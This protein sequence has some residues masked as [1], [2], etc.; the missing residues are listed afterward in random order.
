MLKQLSIQNIALI[1]QQSIAFFDGFS[2]LTGETGAGK[3][4]I[5][6]ALNFVL[7]ERASRELIKSGEEK[8]S[9]EATFALLR[10]DPVQEVLLEQGIDCEEG[11]LVLYREFSAS[12]K[13]VCRANGTLINAGALKLIGDALVDIHGQHAHQS[14]LDEKK[15]LMLLDRFAGK[16]AL[17]IKSR[18]L[19]AYHKAT[20]AR[21]LLSAAQ[22]NEQERI[23]RIDLLSYQ[24]K[25]INAA[26]LTD[27]E[28]EQ[29]E[30]QRGLLQ[31]AQAVMEGLE[32]ASVA[33]SGDEAENG[34]ALA[35]FSTAL[36]NLDGIAHLSADYQQLSE[37]LHALYYDLEDAS[38]TL[39]DYKSDFSFE[40]GMLD[41]IETRLELISTLKRKYGASI[42]EILA[43]REKGVQ[44]LELIEN[45][46]ERREQLAADYANAKAD[47]DALSQELSTLRKQAAEQMRARLIP[48]LS[49]LGMPHAAFSAK[50][51]TLLSE[52]PSAN[53]VDDVVFLLSTNRGEPVKQLSKVASGGELS[54]IMLSFKSVLADLDGIPTMVFDEIDSGISGQIGTAVAVKMRQIAKNH[55]VL[56]ITHLPQ[57][58]AY[59][60]HQYLVYK[61]ETGEHTR[62]NAIKLPEQQRAREIA[63]IMGS[64]GTDAV[65]LEHAQQLIDAA[66]EAMRRLGNA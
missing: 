34:G 29:L 57:I 36:H 61:E 59:A 63:R 16:E 45:A 46:E 13:N 28:E 49:D 6:E 23:R 11:E 51:E 31:N 14:L 25:E 3:S 60:N 33:L 12:G 39:R 53:G 62:S 15:H 55:Q 4:I 22:Y 8:A 52:V 20:E 40:P 7:G 56:C 19:Q 50:F 48:E 32:G 66:E 2:V 24:I 47:Y 27:G 10:D 1:D 18:V 5:I 41:E 35:S 42:A 54:R 30:E 9:V 37:R 26:N 21:R 58:A 44:E 43:Y 38:F 65:A 64:G 17:E